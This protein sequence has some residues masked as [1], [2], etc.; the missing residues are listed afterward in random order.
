MPY[1]LWVGIFNVM[2]IAQFWAFAADLYTPRQGERLFPLIGLGSSLGAWLGAVAATRLI[3]ITGPY[4][5][6]S[7][8]ALIL[9]CCAVLTWWT[10]R[11]HV[12]HP[13]TARETGAGEAAEQ[14]GW[15]QLIFRDH[16]L[17]LIAALVVLLNVVNTSGEFLLG[18]LVVGEA[19]RAFPDA[20][21]MMAERQKF[22]GGFYGEF[23]AWVNITGL[24]VADLLRLEDLQGDRTRQGSVHSSRDRA[25]R[26][27]GDSG[28][29]ASRPGEGAQGDGEQH[30]LLDP[31][32]G[33]AGAFPAYQP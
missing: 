20:A 5:L 18:K 12:R 30:R 2:V 13:A 22:I 8:G 16:Y 25:H 21:T 32:Y 14:R 26:L 31:E 24:I 17:M 3:R 7:A 15:T 1:F 11:V 33:P 4:G 28:G 23:F 19:A 10:D 27:L 29:A 6:M 9:T